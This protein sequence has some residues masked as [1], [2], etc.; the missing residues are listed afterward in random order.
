MCS[1]RLPRSVGKAGENGDEADASIRALDE[2]IERAT[3]LEA[4]YELALS[5]A[6]RVALAA[7]AAVTAGADTSD[8]RDRAET[9]FEGLGVTQAVITWSAPNGGGPLFARRPASLGE[10]GAPGR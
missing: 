3:A 6:N 1:A 9:I 8:D 2:A 5:L 10:A 7:L 4:P